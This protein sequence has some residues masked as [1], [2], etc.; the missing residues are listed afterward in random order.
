MPATA[1]SDVMAE[2]RAISRRLDR[3]ER[4]SPLASSAVSRG[5]VDINSP[6]G[7]HVSGT[8]GLTVD[9]VEDVNGT[10]N[11]EGVEN[12][13]GTLNV[14]G[15]S[16]VTG[17]MN[18]TG[19]MDVEG[20][21]HV[22]G[23]T[24]LDGD[25]DMTGNLHQTAGT[26][27]FDSDVEINGDTTLSALLE[28][29]SG[30]SIK[31]DGAHPITIGQQGGNAVIDMG[32]AD[33]TSDGTYASFKAGNVWAGVSA[34]VALLSN[35]ARTVRVTSTGVQIIGLSTAPSGSGATPL[36]IGSDGYLYI[37]GTPV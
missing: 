35:G 2:L 29:L 10:L 36:L 22:T 5:G 28:I 21:L 12:I 14:Q 30:G 25:I 9:G 11:V 19:P 6:E 31:I 37:G 15:E 17:P 16:S 7:L 1:P 20:N 4:Q 13:S 3:L 32:V 18:V 33:I 26:V 8:G 34:A 24:D 23:P 27:T